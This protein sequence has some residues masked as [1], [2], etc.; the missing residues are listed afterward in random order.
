MLHPLSKIPYNYENAKDIFCTPVF[1]CSCACI[2][3]QEKKHVEARE[4]MA[5]WVRETCKDDSSSNP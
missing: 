1:L 3:K 5:Q 2:I 4:I